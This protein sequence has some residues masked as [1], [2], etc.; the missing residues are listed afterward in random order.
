MNALPP[1]DLPAAPE[2]LEHA[3][4]TI[5]RMNAASGGGPTDEFGRW[6]ADY[7][8]GSGGAVGAAKRIAFR[9]NRGDRRVAVENLIAWGVYQLEHGN[10]PYARACIENARKGAGLD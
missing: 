9:R 2:L 8:G 10:V 4:S 6:W 3:K 5:A 1:G 7:Q